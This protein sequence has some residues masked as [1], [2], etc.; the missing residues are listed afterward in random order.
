MGRWIALLASLVGGA[1]G[2]WNRPPVLVI[3]LINLIPVAGV[4]WFAWSPLL[5]LLLYWA[6][7]VFVGVFNWL[8]LRGFEA[9][10]APGVEPF[11]ISSFFAMHYGMFTL[12]HGIFA[13]VVGGLMFSGDEATHA[14]GVGREGGFEWLSFLIAIGSI[15]LLHL[16]DYVRWRMSQGW[17]SGS[18]DRQMMAPYGRIIVMHLTIIGGAAVLAATDAPVTYIALLAVL[19]TFIE[20]GWAL[21]GD[22]QAA[23]PAGAMTITIDGKT[24]RSK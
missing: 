1:L 3:L 12:V 23:G 7:N 24:W 19:K 16:T 13:V 14:A 8:K 18:L 2:F 22:K 10:K 15:A 20:T 9:Q 21:M 4:L 17:K 11:R 6:E 5:L